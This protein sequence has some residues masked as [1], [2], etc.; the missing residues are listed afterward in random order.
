MARPRSQSARG[1][2]PAP[3][4][5]GPPNVGERPGASDAPVSASPRV[6][7]GRQCPQEALLR[8]PTGTPGHWLDQAGSVRRKAAAPK[9]TQSPARTANPESARHPLT[10]VPFFEPRSTSTHV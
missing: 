4:A 6:P 2:R 8:A 1:R 7:G 3:S 9:V 10:R 5:S